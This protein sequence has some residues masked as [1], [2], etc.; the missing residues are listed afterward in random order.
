M[1]KPKKTLKISPNKKPQKKLRT[2]KWTSK[3]NLS[4]SECKLA[5]HINTG[6]NMVKYSNVS[7]LLTHKFMDAVTSDED[8]DL[9]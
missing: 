5:E 2:K 7:V 3:R 4:K 9:H 8:F 6:I 1:V